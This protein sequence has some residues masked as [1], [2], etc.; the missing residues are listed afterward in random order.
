MKQVFQCDYCKFMGTKD[1]VKEH[2]LKCI[3]NYD[4][5]SCFTCKHRDFKSLNQYKCACGR[6]IQEG[7]I[8]EFCSQYERKEKPKGDS[9]KLRD[10][11]GNLFGF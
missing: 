3:D 9:S 6:E 11:F 10:I 4:R 7:M 8:F 5:K 2:E 1:E